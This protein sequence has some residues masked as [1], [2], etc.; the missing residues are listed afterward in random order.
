MT[1]LVR[2]L[3]LALTAGIL[4]PLVRHY[5]PQYAPILAAAVSFGALALLFLAGTEVIAW[6]TQLGQ[7]VNSEAFRCL[8]KAAGLL[9]CTQW[10]CDLCCDNGLTSAAGCIEIAG[11]S[12]ALAAAFPILRS[13]Y[14]GIAGLL[15]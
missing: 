4:Y 10:C 15:G 14:D 2:L 3:A 7:A 12:L 13:F 11:R 5:V 6:F 1:E 8:L 9:F